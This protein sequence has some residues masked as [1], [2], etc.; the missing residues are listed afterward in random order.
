[1]RGPWQDVGYPYL[2]KI[3]AERAFERAELIPFALILRTIGL[4]WALL[5]RSEGPPTPP[6]PRAFWYHTLEAPPVSYSWRLSPFTDSIM[7]SLRLEE[8]AGERSVAPQ[9][10]GCLLGPAASSEGSRAPRLADSRC[11]SCGAPWCSDETTA[12]DKGSSR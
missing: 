8:Q 2:E 11:L 5:C 9:A 1:M 10:N 4:G 12:G 7:F 6:L 3:G